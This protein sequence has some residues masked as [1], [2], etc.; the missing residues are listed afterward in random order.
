[1]EISSIPRPKPIGLFDP[2]PVVTAK[3][4]NGT[5]KELFSFYPDEIRFDE[6]ELVG[7]TE[8]EAHSLRQRKDAEYLR[9]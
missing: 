2:T 6:G 8:A 4:D 3:F 1:V 5:R 7:L 9:T